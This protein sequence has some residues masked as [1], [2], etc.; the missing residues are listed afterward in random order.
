[1][2]KCVLKEEERGKGEGKNRGEN[3]TERGELEVNMLYS[4]SDSDMWEYMS[5]LEDK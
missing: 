5:Y 1:M 3:K 4:C 2:R